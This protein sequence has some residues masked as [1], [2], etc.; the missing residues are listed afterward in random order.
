MYIRICNYIYSFRIP[1]STLARVLQCGL[2]QLLP[3]ALVSGGRPTGAYRH[4]A[5]I[6]DRCLFVDV[7]ILQNDGSR[8]GAHS[9]YIYT[10]ILYIYIYIYAYIYK[11][12]T[13]SALQLLCPADAKERRD[14]G[15][16]Q[17]R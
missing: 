12:I 3:H 16:L 4:R 13:A 7:E 10:Y 8:I 15:V 11:C 1:S 5:E 9:I 14:I 2:A 17:L 6:L